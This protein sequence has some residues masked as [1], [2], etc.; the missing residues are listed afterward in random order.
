MTHNRLTKHQLAGRETCSA[1]VRE[2]DA[3][4]VSGVLHEEE[5]E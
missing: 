4:Q 3:M 1:L 5:A 2:R